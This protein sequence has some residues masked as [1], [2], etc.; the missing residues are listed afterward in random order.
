M[1]TEA[2][3]GG[4]TTA[5]SVMNTVALE[6]VPIVYRTLG[7][8]DISTTSTPSSTESIP[9]DNKVICADGLAIVVC[10]VTSV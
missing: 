10:E 5:A 9:A 6:G 8:K 3:E 1:G 4:A 2:E 7:V